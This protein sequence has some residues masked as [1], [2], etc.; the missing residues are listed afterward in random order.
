MAQGSSVTCGWGQWRLQTRTRALASSTLSSVPCWTRSSTALETLMCRVPWGGCSQESETWHEG[1][2]EGRKHSINWVCWYTR[3][4]PA[5]D[6]GC[7]RIKHSVLPL[8]V[9]LRSAWAAR[10][11]VSRKR[12]STIHSISRFFRR[13]LF[14]YSSNISISHDKYKSQA[15]WNKNWDLY[16]FFLLFYTNFT[17]FYYSNWKW[18]CSPN[19]W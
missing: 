6:T 15:E 2:Q 18:N 1:E 7:K 13:D 4:F 9:I 19:I 17:L 14:Y 5:F 12:K 16:I 11:P 3:V 8:I 10:G